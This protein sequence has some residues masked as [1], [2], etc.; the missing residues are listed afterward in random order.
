[1][2]RV[3]GFV[4]GWMTMEKRYLLDNESGS[5]RIPV[6]SILIRHP[7]GSIVFDTGLHPDLIA[8]PVNPLRPIEMYQQVHMAAGEDLAS[9]LQSVDVDPTSIRQVINSHLHF[10]HC[11]A[12]TQLP[13]ARVVLQRRE[14][15]A[16]QDERGRELAYAVRH[17]EDA[18]PR[19]LIDGEHDIFGDGSVRC[20]PTYGHSHGHQSLLVKTSQGEM[21]FAADACYLCQSLEKLQGP[22]PLA[23][24]DGEAAHRSLQWIHQ[25]WERGVRIF[26]GHEPAMWDSAEGGHRVLA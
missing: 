18:Q 21:L 25:Q 6:Y 12:N 2:L 19:L 26:P 14:W 9:R 17:W 13:N 15:D 8:D 16:A 11:G 7:A 3:D 20:I 5:I 1:M 22:D 24:A 4:C 10:D 23:H